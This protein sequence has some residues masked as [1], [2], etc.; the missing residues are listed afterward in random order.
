MLC[1]K[2]TPVAEAAAEL[3]TRRHAREDLIDFTAYTFPSFEVAGHHRLIAEK[4]V[5]V[6]RGEIDRLMIFCPP[7]HGKSELAPRRFPAWFL[8]RHPNK[9][10]IC[11]SY[12]DDLAHEFGRDVWNIVALV[13]GVRAEVLTKCSFA[14]IAF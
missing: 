6:E 3:L 7:R 8:G 2:P 12:G 4:L 14:C 1:T 11:C 5:A 13:D 10:I 9:Q